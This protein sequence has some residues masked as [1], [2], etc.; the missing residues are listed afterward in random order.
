MVRQMSLNVNIRR[1]PSIGDL[2]DLI[3][4]GLSGFV[5]TTINNIGISSGEFN[6]DDVSDR[7][8]LKT[9]FVLFF[10]NSQRHEEQDVSG[11]ACKYQ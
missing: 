9:G 5:L 1:V 4:S 7:T 11:K 3:S 8:C 2:S 10:I 6:P